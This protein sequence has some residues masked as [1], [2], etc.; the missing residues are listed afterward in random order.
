MTVS[1]QV[2]ALRQG[3]IDLGFLRDVGVLGHLQ[4]AVLYSEPLVAVM[5]A[6]DPLTANKAVSIADLG[7]RPFIGI[8]Y[9]NN[10]S[11]SEMLARIFKQAG[12]TPE[13]VSYASDMHTILCLVMAG[14]GVSI[15]P[16]SVMTVGLNMVTYRPLSDVSDLIEAS[17][18]WRR[19]STCECLP[20]FID[21][22]K[23]SIRTKIDPSLIPSYMNG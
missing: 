12:I 9:E 16:A 22:A 20:G 4:T 21:A 3:R 18:A 6:T 7:Q 2:Q 5:G 23:R 1:Q 10:A 14:F 19:D 11:Y 13:I 15:V 8:A 17:M